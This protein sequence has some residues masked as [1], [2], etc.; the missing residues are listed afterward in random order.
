MKFEIHGPIFNYS[1]YMKWVEQLVAE[2][3]T[4]GS[5]QSEALVGFTALNLR[6]MQRLNKTIELIP[7]LM[8]QV[9]NMESMQT[10]YLLA[11]AWCGDCA[12]IIPV[13]GKISEA[14]EG[15]ID[16]KI[17][18]RDANPTWIAHYH[19]NGSLSVPKLIAFDQKGKELFTWGPRPSLAQS[20]IFAWKS[21]NKGR[22]W[23]DFESELHLWYAKDKTM[24]T[25]KEFVALLTTKSYSEINFSEVNE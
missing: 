5:K 1:Q 17:F 21:D 18:D 15:L 2:G 13:I 6:R 9:R 7:E 8:N 12:Q 4:S 10:W 24:S 3:K 19:T 11:E 14:S 16:L 23:D 25:Q 20:M 22:S